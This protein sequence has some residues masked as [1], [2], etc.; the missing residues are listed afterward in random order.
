M[1]RW[2]RVPTLTNSEKHELHFLTGARLCIR[3]ETE[4]S[5]THVISLITDVTKLYVFHF[6]HNVYVSQTHATIMKMTKVTTGRRA[7]IESA[8]AS[9]KR[10]TKY[11]DNKQQA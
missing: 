4:K 6:T 3:A 1:R 7:V 5:E 2:L 11:T 10:T 9:I 8:R